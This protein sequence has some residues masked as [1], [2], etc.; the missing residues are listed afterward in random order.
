VYLVSRSEVL[1][2]LDL[3]SGRSLA[4]VSAPHEFLEWLDMGIGS[5]TFITKS[6]PD[7]G[8]FDTIL[9]WADPLWDEVEILDLCKLLNGCGS[10]WVVA[11]GESPFSNGPKDTLPLDEERSLYR[12][13]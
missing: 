4:I 8:M 7:R 13:I 12:L 10:V 6:L 5:D 11:S 2:H 3:V 9:I 1:R